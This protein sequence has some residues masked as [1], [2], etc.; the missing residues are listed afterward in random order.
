MTHAAVLEKALR[1]GGLYAA[2][3]GQPLSTADVQR[4]VNLV[5]TGTADGSGDA[6]LPGLADEQSEVTVNL[7]SYAMDGTT[8]S[9]IH[10]SAR[11]PYRPLLGKLTGSIG[12]DGFMLELD[13]EQ[14][15]VG[16]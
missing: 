11:V 14:P 15:S 2:L 4:A 1:S 16:D 9:V 7:R 13:H 10:M 8:V 6:L 3:S 12:L 5:R